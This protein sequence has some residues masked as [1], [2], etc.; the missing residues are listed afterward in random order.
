MRIP[1]L[2]LAVA[3][4]ASL[5]GAQI[6]P[7]RGDCITP[8]PLPIGGPH[9]VR[10]AS[11]VHVTLIGRVLRYEVTETFVNRGSGIGEADYLLPLP[12]GAAFEDLALEINGELVAGE[13][14]P[15]D[16]ARG[17]YEE[18]VRKTRD[19][20]LVEWM[21]HGLLRARIFPIAAGESKKVVVRFRAV[22]QREG[23]A[24]RIEYTSAGRTPGSMEQAGAPSLTL[25]LPRGDGFGTPWS[26]TH[27]VDV[28]DRGDS[29]EVRVRG[30]ASRLT[31][32]VPIPSSA[33]AT[34]TS[35]PFA[36][37]GEDGFALI[38]LTPPATRT[39]GMPRDIT[40]VVDISGSMSG[41]KIEQARAAGRTLLGALSRGDRFRLISFS[42]DVDEFRTGWTDA[43]AANV[44]EGQRWLADL[45][46]TG[47]TNISGALERA[48]DEVPGRGR[49][50]AVLFQTDGAATIGE[51]NP[52]RLA[53][54]ASQR[55]GGMRLFTFG[56]GSDVQAGL[57]ERI[58]IEGH[59]TAHFVQPNED[60]EYAVGVVSQRLTAPVATNVRLRS[61]GVTLRQVQPDGAQDLFN[62]QD[63]TF[64]VRYRGSGQATLTFDGD[65]P[66]GHVEWTERADFP[67]RSRDNSYVAKLWA[68]Q[69]V[70]WLSAERRRSGAT[71]E[72]DNELRDLGTKYGIPT[73]L[74]SYLVVEPGMQQPVIDRMLQAGGR[75]GGSR[76]AAG[77]ATDFEAARKAAEQRQTRNLADAMA[78][79]VAVP[80]APVSQAADPKRR[81]ETAQGLRQVGDRTFIF[82]KDGRWMDTRFR[83]SV[84]K[85]TVRSFS[86]A[87]FALM[88]RIPELK[89]AFALGDR[90]TVA[91]RTVVVVLDA[92]GVEQLPASDLAAVERDW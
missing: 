31:L 61:D 26:P 73:E 69:R 59:G 12:K 52:D 44:A 53:A 76:G 50:G 6:A 58:A 2:I 13:A 60:V 63:L 33:R 4:Q 67:G 39:A 71:P 45:R 49:F 17:I 65:T 27:H 74:T 11:D 48:F 25:I 32:L 16:R 30:D 92:Q 91:G 54:L 20:A 28:S 75:G 78:V 43:T 88:Q 57:L 10:T 38:T 18:I 42:T 90:V 77:A 24:L 29:R 5:A 83:D 35:L 51:R 72:L 23:N 19:P 81:D 3:A 87:Y 14:L 70:G 89:G 34:V 68:V 86:A 66:A 62:G 85:V 82:A 84:R 37:P 47:S 1:A 64:L 8:R 56:I 9:I 15:S 46:A 36:P 79:S 21:D 80:A 22:A 41:N 40:F 7:C 55:R